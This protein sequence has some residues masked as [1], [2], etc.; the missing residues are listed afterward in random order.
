[1]NHIAHVVV[2]TLVVTVVSPAIGAEPETQR[3][4]TDRAKAEAACKKGMSLLDWPR[5]GSDAVKAFDEAIRLDPTYAEAYR[6]RGLA[7][8]GRR[9]FDKAI[10]D[11]SEA[12]RLEPQDAKAYCGRA[13]TRDQK[14][15]WD[16]AIADYTQAIKI[17]PKYA[18]AYLGRGEAYWHNSEDDKAIAD[19]TQAIPLDPAGAHD[20]L[21]EVFGQHGDYNRAITEL[22]QAIRAEPKNWRLY[23]GRGNYY[24]LV[25]KPDRAVADCT[26]AI[27]LL[28]KSGA[29][30]AA[31][32]YSTRGD[33]YRE[34]GDLDKAIADY[35]EGLRLV[36]YDSSMYLSL[37]AAYSAKGDHRNAIAIY[38]EMIRRGES[39]LAYL[40]RG[41]EYQEDRRFDEAIADFTAGLR[42]ISREDETNG[43]SPPN[44][45]ARYAA[46][47]R[48]LSAWIHTARGSAY[49]SKGE[50]DKAIA[51]YTEAIRLNPRDADARHGRG[52]AYQKK[53]DRVKAEADFTEAKKLGYKGK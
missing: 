10:V 53:G 25:K 11:F 41:L 23:L 50:H 24:R 18:P 37:G 17:A 39:S 44:L 3:K 45:Q 14:A 27:R 26:E 42:D 16:A 48:A 47:N 40:N 51:D 5:S 12:I 19:Y 13:E 36:P 38:T 46:Q 1:M 33:I 34:R 8:R 49:E 35:K 2:C 21:S 32:A 22:T 28:P 52:L 6:G 4:P 9:E 7:Y 30:D 31:S 20:H 43:T 29:W 15:D